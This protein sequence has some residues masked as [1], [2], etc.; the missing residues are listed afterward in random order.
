[1]LERQTGSSRDLTEVPRVFCP[2]KL[3]IHSKQASSEHQ[4]RPSPVGEPA[5]RYRSDAIPAQNEANQAD[6]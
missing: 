3:G 5:G 2:E 6:C 1:M 4:P